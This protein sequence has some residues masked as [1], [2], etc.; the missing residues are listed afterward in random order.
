MLIIQ[1]ILLC[2]VLA[3]ILHATCHYGCLCSFSKNSLSAI[4]PP[5]SCLN[6][7]TLTPCVFL[8][9]ISHTK[10]RSGETTS[11]W[12]KLK[13]VLVFLYVPA[14][15]F[16]LIYPICS[17]PPTPR[18]VLNCITAAPAMSYGT[19]WFIEQFW[20]GY[21]RAKDKVISPLPNRN[22]EFISLQ[23]NRPFFF[24]FNLILCP[25]LNQSLHV[26]CALVGRMHNVV[27]RQEKKK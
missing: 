25:H 4:S 1:Y 22:T 6:W 13:C 19:P 10:N 27:W 18:V 16:S 23:S 3:L 5:F 2:L 26:V 9:H 14:N 12:N 8:Y 20:W 17:S 21:E 7:N 11:E 15:M 24:F